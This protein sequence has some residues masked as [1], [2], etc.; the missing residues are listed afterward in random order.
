MKKPW[1]PLVL[2][3]MFESCHSFWIFNDFKRKKNI[4]PEYMLIQAKHKNDENACM[5]RRWRC[6][7]LYWCKTLVLFFTRL[8]P[9]CSQ[10]IKVSLHLP[11]LHWARYRTPRCS[12]KSLRWAGLQRCALPSPLCSWDRLQRPA[13]DPGRDTA[14]KKR[15]K[16]L[17]EVWQILWWLS[18]WGL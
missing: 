6:L 12:H 4:I 3:F 10:T 2:Y 5:W 1:W 18:C 15:N 8:K 14:V 13:R 7:Q 11:R 16:T 9:W 17:L